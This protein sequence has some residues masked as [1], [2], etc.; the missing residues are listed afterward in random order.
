MAK[1]EDADIMTGFAPVWNKPAEDNDPDAE[2]TQGAEDDEAG[3]GEGASTALAT[4]EAPAEVEVQLDGRRIRVGK[5]IADAFTREINRRDG[6]R[7]A[8]LQGLRE[9]LAHLEGATIAAKTQPDAEARQTPQVPNPELQIENPEEY[10]RQLLEF[11]NFN[12]EARANGL[13]RQYEEAEAAKSAEAARRTA[14]S[15]HVKSFYSL[16]ENTMLRDKRDIVD[17]VL[18]QNRANLA[19]LSV[20]SGFA[21]LGRLAKAKL[22]MLTGTSPEARART[23]PKPPVLE[24]STRRDGASRPAAAKDEGPRSLTQALKDRRKM[25]AE[26]FRKGASDAAI[27]QALRAGGAHPS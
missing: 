9:R 1:L 27:K 15:A 22:A 25:V 17:L 26:S 21:E 12:Q 7:G 19:P 20:E 24:G 18:Q 23:T 13:A 6:T 10:Q 8:E 14:W 11:I 16:P 2:T 5:D 3:E 4:S